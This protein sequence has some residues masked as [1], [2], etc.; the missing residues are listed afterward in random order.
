MRLSRCNLISASTKENVSLLL[1]KLT[2]KHYVSFKPVDLQE[3]E[4]TWLEV[5]GFN[6]GPIYI[7]LSKN[8]DLPFLLTSQY[9]FLRLHDKRT[10]R[11]HFLWYSVKCGCVGGCNFFGNNRNGETFFHP[12]SK[13][14]ENNTNVAIPHI[15]DN[16]KDGFGF[17]QS[18]LKPKK[19]VFSQTP[20]T[21]AEYLN[22]IIKTNWNATPGSTRKSISDSLKLFFQKTNIDGKK[23]IPG[24]IYK[25][26]SLTEL[27]K[28]IS[29]TEHERSLDSSVDSM[30]LPYL[31]DSD[32]SL[33]PIET[34][35]KAKI[36][37]KKSE[38]YF[39]YFYFIYV[40]IMYLF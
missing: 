28:Q 8:L 37:I 19:N 29:I 4:D 6:L 1:P 39:L 23:K 27:K 9:D 30:P 21:A 16:P 18:I 25:K 12:S 34:D 14:K 33:R 20:L 3:T 2:L 40:L 26:K 36:A 17:Q 5:G 13:D 32:V 15:F 35:S 10:K 22:K 24:W 38:K 7:D 11:L 31:S